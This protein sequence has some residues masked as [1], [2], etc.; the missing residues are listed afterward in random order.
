MKMNIINTQNNKTLRLNRQSGLSLIELMIS[1]VVGLFLLAG[2][3]TNFISTKDADV[4][5]VAVGEM[6]ANAAAVF[7]ILRSTISHAGYS[8]IENITIDKPFFTS[9]DGSVANPSCR[10]GS[11]RDFWTPRV[12]RRTRDSATRD[13]LTVISLAD[14]PCIAGKASCPP[15]SGDE[16]PDALVYT[17]CT[18]GGATRDSRTVSCS[19]DLDVGMNDPTQARIYSSFWL[20]K[21]TSSPEDR[22]LY[23]DGSRGGRQPIVNDV[24]AI[25]YL[26]GITNAAGSTTYRT[27]NQIEAA[28]QWGMVASVRVG[29]L[30]RSSNPNVLDQPST[31]KRYNLLKT[32]INIANADL[33]RL[34]R[35]YTTTIN[36]ENKNTGALL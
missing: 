11:K 8:S 30:M 16:N 22:T 6:D 20:L 4:R 23:C 31:K 9:S 26:Y 15:G 5:R 3:V 33:K 29:L 2:V 25:Q 1:M 17:D 18:G 28:D 21:N 7:N 10:D 19:T 12:N 13:F 32:N 27:A 24:E 36:L 35:V 34:F 14:N